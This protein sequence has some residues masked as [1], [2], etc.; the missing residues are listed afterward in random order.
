[1]SVSFILAFLA[2][3][4]WIPSPLAIGSLPPDFRLCRTGQLSG[5]H[6]CGSVITHY[7]TFI[8]RLQSI[9]GS[10]RGYAA[11]AE[12]SAGF[13]VCSVDTNRKTGVPAAYLQT[14]SAHNLLPTSISNSADFSMGTGDAEG[15]AAGL[16]PRRSQ[17]LRQSFWRYHFHRCNRRSCRA[18]YSFSAM[19]VSV[20]RRPSCRTL[21][22]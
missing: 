16:S 15:R 11:S 19:K 1:M 20:I 4:R 8:L 17:R 13:A 10:P 7:D 22:S 18:A 3:V 2:L 6:F 12:A 14:S 5:R 9:V 21:F